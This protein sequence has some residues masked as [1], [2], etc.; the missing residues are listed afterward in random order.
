[1]SGEVRR[2]D[3]LKAEYL[4]RKAAVR[5][6]ETSSWEKKELKVKALRDEYHRA[7]KEMEAA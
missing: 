2:P 3:E 6:D 1:M 4:K 5:A 7:R